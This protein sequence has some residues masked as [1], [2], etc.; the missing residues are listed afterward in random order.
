MVQGSRVLRPYPQGCEFESLRAKVSGKG[1]PGIGL[2]RATLPVT[3]DASVLWPV[4]KWFQVER[5]KYIWVTRQQVLLEAINEYMS[6][7]EINDYLNGASLHRA[8]DVAAVM[9]CLVTCRRCWACGRRAL[10]TLVTNPLSTRVTM[11]D[12]RESTDPYEFLQIVYNPNDD[13]LT[14]HVHFPCSNL[15]NDNSNRP[16]SAKDAPLNTHHNTW[17]RLYKPTTTSPHKLPLIL[18]FHGS[19]FIL[20]RATD[21]IYH[22]FCSRLAAELPAVVISVKYRLALENRLPTTYE[23]AEEAIKW[24]REQAIMDEENKGEV[25]K[26]TG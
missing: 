9:T 7:I 5:A 23:D 8:A 1:D 18:Y 22:D 11:A 2:V 15:K 6:T 19:G 17:L 10:H 24:V 4:V 26:R 20:C 21:S 16:F 25:V 12:L 3:S 14:R 13:T